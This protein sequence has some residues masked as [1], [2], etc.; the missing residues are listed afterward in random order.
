LPGPIRI[1]LLAAIIRW[2]LT[3]LS[4]PLLARQFWFS[5]ASIITIAGC[6][7]LSILLN[8]RVEEYVSR[9][10]QVRKLAG[11]TSVL[12]LARRA[13]DGLIVFAGVMVTL[14]YFGV[15]PT[16]ALAGLGVGGIAVAFAAQKT[17]EN[18]IGGI[19]IILDGAVRVGDSLS[20][21]DILGTVDDIG[22]RSTRIRTLDRSMVSVP[23]GQIANLSLKNLSARDR[24]WF[25]PIL[26][27]GY[28][29]T[30]EQMT[31]VLESIRTLLGETRLV[32]PASVH[33]RFLNFGT[34]FLEV[35]VFA[36]I[37]ARDWNKFLEI[38]EGILLRIMRC[39]ESAGV[40]M[41]LPSQ[42]IFVA[43]TSA[44]TESGGVGLLKLPAPDKKTSDQASA[45][46]A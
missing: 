17:L 43:S 39:V 33:V 34:S 28:G 4:L 7:W 31:A 32:D 30:S 16:A 25:H 42:T 19:S 26:R 15:K 46:S 36:Y 29:T 2:L 45:K 10:L 5:T 44:S 38:Q 1:L 6:V 23:N 37:L 27:L 22:L 8:G 9:R 14:Y 35:E 3:Q 12:R 41:A 24:F 18:V 21:G 20:V 11:T 13:I 40:H